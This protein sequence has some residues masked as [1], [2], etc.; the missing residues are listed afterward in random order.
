M[1]RKLG[2]T[3]RGDTATIDDD[4]LAA[5]GSLLVEVEI[6][7]PLFFR[8]L[9]QVPTS[10]MPEPAIDAAFAILREAYYAPD[11]VT[12]FQ[13]GSLRSWLARYAARVRIEGI[14]DRERK[15]RMDAVNPLYVPRNYLVQQV[16][17]A[18][19]AGD[20][21]ALP[22]LLDVL[23][24]PYEEQPGRGNFAGKRPDWARHKP[25]CSMLSCSS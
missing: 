15:T 9:A 18:T 7:M 20:R 10:A 21:K 8:R 23:R 4:L 14:D 6:D 24:H 25:G 5:L 19:E 11:Q 3:G 12:V 16:I 2:L 13:R 22:E 17:E 1:L